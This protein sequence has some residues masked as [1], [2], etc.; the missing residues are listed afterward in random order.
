MASARL[1]NKLE[2]KIED[3]EKTQY[4]SLLFIKSNAELIQGLQK[5]ERLRSITLL[6]LA[7]SQ[8]L[9]ALG[10]LIQQLISS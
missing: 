8:M 4:D 6:L 3:L 10:Q 1:E 5:R 2:K 7:L 9:L